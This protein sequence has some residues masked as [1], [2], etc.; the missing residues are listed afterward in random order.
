M[1]GSRL[2]TTPTRHGSGDRRGLHGLG[3]MTYETAK[4]LL[5]V[6][7]TFADRQEAIRWAMVMGMPLRQI[8][9]YLD[10][11]ELAWPMWEAAG[12]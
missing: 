2:G 3:I 4:L 7:G 8:E 10:W 11:F 12:D 9:E 5:G 6:A 1:L